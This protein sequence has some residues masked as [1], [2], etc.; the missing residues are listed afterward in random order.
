VPRSSPSGGFTFDFQPWNGGLRFSFSQVTLG[1]SISQP[2]ISA[3]SAS[4]AE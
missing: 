1:P 3:T 2:Q 4:Y